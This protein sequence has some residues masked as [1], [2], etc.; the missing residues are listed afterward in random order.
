MMC[1]IVFVITNTN[2]VIV[3]SIIYYYCTVNYFSVFFVLFLLVKYK[4]LTR[5][6]HQ[7]RLV[8]KYFGCQVFWLSSI[9]VV[10]YF[11]C[12]V[13]WLSSILAVKYKIE[14]YALS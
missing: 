14:G 2:T 5:L 7:V 1:V 8:V 10:K 3:I 6:K 11:G 9:L 12:Q 4:L 13:F